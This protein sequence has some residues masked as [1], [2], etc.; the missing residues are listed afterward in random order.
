MVGMLLGAVGGVIA[1][2]GNGQIVPVAIGVALK[3]LGS[4]PACYMI[5]A[6][7]A[8]VIDHIDTIRDPYRWIDNVYLQFHHGSCELRYVTLFS[9]QS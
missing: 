5:L 6:I 9:V 3:C 7:L 8:D 4:A 2:M 1:I